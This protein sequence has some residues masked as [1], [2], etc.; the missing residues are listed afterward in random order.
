MEEVVKNSMSDEVYP[1]FDLI[2][3]KR[4]PKTGKTIAVNPYRLFV[5]Q[6]TQYFER[7]KG[8]GNLFFKSGK[9][10]GRRV[11]DGGKYRIRENEAHVEMEI[12][13]SKEQLTQL[14]LDM[15]DQQLAAAKAEIE[16]LKREKKQSLPDGK[17]EATKGKKSAK[18]SIEVIAQG[19]K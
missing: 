17:L 19:E 6:G 15:K 9:P 18:D 7:P 8:S 5:V 2:V 1:A 3:H 16:A 10:A 11:L 14:E 13:P 12:A 4:H